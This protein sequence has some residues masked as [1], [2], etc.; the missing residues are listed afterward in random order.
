MWGVMEKGGGQTLGLVGQIECVSIVGS[1]QSANIV[2]FSTLQDLGEGS[3][4][5][6]Q[7]DRPVA[8]ILGKSRSFKLDGDERDVR[9]V[10]RLQGL[11]Q[12]TMNKRG[13]EVR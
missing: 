12:H 2:V 10:H 4:V 3:Q 7:R 5:D 11:P 13:S 9:V 6:A 1:L 8:T